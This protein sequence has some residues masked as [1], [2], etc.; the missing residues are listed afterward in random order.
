MNQ[1]QSTLT[2]DESVAQVM[3]ALPPVIRDYL[4]QGK[5]TVIAK[6]LIARYGLRVDQGGV[7][8]REIML[9]LMGIESPEEFTQALT[10]EA[11]LPQQTVSLLMQEVNTQIFIPLREQIRSGGVVQPQKSAA[12]S[13]A[14]R[15]TAPMPMRPV[16]IPIPKYYAPPPQSPAYFRPDNKPTPSPLVS[17]IAPLPPKV[18]MPRVPGAP[19]VEAPLVLNG[20]GQASVNLIEPKPEIHH[21]LPPPPPVP[22]PLTPP[23]PPIPPVPAETPLRQALRAVAPQDLSGAMP[24]PDIIPSAPKKIV[25]PPS[26]SGVDP[27]REPIE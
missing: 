19:S 1:D 20:G 18:V 4:V 23:T 14:P 25:P 13:A 3:R 27:Y 22:A 5:S 16:S 6:S 17:N 24:P 9:L 12:T 2:F 8:E 10:E 7:L 11:K 21:E 15:P 26:T